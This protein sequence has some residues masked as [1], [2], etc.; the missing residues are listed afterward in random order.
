MLISLNIRLR[1]YPLRRITNY[2]AP[3]DATWKI[4]GICY[5][6]WV[7]DKFGKSHA[8]E[9]RKFRN[10]NPDISWL[11]F[12]EN[13]LN[14]YMLKFWGQHPIYQVFIKSK[15]GP[16][17]AD[18]FRYCILFDRGG[19]YFD[20]SKGCESPIRMMHDKNCEALISFENNSHSNTLE[21]ETSALLDHP[22]NLIIQWGF[23]FAKGHIFLEEVIRSIVDRYRD[24]EGTIFQN[25]K[26]AILE[27]T[28]PRAFTAAVQSKI[29]TSNL[30][31]VTQAGIDFHGR[32]IYALRGSFV[33]YFTEEHYTESSNSSLF[34]D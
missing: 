33:R 10:L 32:G 9:I 11:L 8:S 4:P 27:L 7:D 21:V 1:E 5:Q 30:Q 28:G 18:I 2:T 22:H 19:Y 34:Y 12:D 14:D 29:N 16:M 17:R 3:L 26:E 6:T 15:F 20:I 31:F 24:Y 13:K 25:P 23:G